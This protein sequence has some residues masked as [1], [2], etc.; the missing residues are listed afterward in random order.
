MSETAETGGTRWCVSDQ[1]G[2][3]VVKWDAGKRHRCPLCWA[4]A[5]DGQPV[6]AWAVYQCCRCGRR[7]CSRPWLAWAMPF[8]GVA[9]TEHRDR[10]PGDV[11]GKFVYRVHP[12]PS[13]SG[14]VREVCED[15]TVGLSLTDGTRDWTTLWDIEG[16]GE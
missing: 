10:R 16:R 1:A 7:F 6:S 12:L 4:V 14:V 15:G 8:L 3:P 11:D 2:E 5:V 9:C 13:V